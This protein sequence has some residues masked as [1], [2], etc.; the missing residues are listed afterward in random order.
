MQ[1]AN[2]VT[3]GMDV[4][5]RYCQIAVLDAGGTVVGTAR[6]A[7]EL[8]GIRRWFG[9]Y[10]ESR[11]V[12]E[13]GTHSPWLSRLLAE[14]GHEVIVAN[15]AMGGIARPGAAAPVQP[16]GEQL[17][18]AEQFIRNTTMSD[19]TR[20]F[21][22]SGSEQLHRARRRRGGDALADDRGRADQLRP[23]ERCLRP[24]PAEGLRDRPG[25]V[26]REREGAVPVAPGFTQRCPRAQ[27]WPARAAHRPGAGCARRRPERWPQA[28]P[29]R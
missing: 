28:R 2:T 1:T 21:G 5:D 18:P 14:Q 10:P 26:G 16:A 15:P 3:I 17:S 29:Q 20:A 8:A 4:S 13:V 7:T 23:A 25:D 27:P 11:V 9:R 22:G 19:G 6:V 24:E 12:L